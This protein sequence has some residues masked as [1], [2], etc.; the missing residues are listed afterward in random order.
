MKK[1]TATI[2]AAGIAALTALPALAQDMTLR[3]GTFATSTSPWGQAMKAFSDI[4]GEKTDGRIKIEVYTDGQIGGMQQLLTGMQLG[5]IDMAYFDVTVAAFLKGAEE[6]K[7]AI[8]P[9]LFDTKAD[10]AKVLNSELFQKIYEDIAQRTGVRIFAA[11]G[12]RS[13]RAIQTTKGPI[14]TP[15]D[16]KGFRMRVAGIDI[17]EAMFETLGTQITPLGMTEIYNALSRGIVDG[18]DNGFELAVPPKFHEVAKY[19]SA[20]DHV[21]GVTGWFISEQVWNRLSDDDKQIFR[22]A[23]K[24][25]GKV[26]TDA[27]NALDAKGREILE[28]AGVTYTEPDREAFKE[29]LKDVYKDFEG[30]VWPD[31]LVAQI[32]ALQDQD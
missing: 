9:Y 16:L 20:T 13:P 17:Y 11:Y 8:V 12:D 24:A 19:W 30:T 4:V 7:V 28:E 22:E 25:A 5:T 15:E 18:Q 1:F 26:S 3:M 27:T 32:R 2:A 10:A 6:I 21:Y 23:G 14:E 29:A 31:G